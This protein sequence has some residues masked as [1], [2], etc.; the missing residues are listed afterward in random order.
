MHHHIGMICYGVIGLILA[1][2]SALAAVVPSGYPAD[3]YGL[4][5]LAILAFYGFVRLILRVT[6]DNAK[7]IIASNEAVQREIA[8]LAATITEHNAKTIPDIIERHARLIAEMQT[9][10]R[11]QM[12]KLTEMMQVV[13]ACRF[14]QAA[15]HPTG[16]K[17]G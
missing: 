7:G 16:E 10:H 4:A 8:G 9:L 3:E 2:L 1:G 14:V 6:T 17:E 15:F 12:A 13:G 11:D 5:A